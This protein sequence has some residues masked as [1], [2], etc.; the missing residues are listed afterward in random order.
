LLGERKGEYRYW[1]KSLQAFPAGFERQISVSV[2]AIVFKGLK[3]GCTQK[4]PWEHRFYDTT[5]DVKT[6]QP[7][8]F[9]RL[10][11]ILWIV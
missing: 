2:N 1:S 4:C 11:L 10:I 6:H 7:L 9:Q 8:I 3:A 5:L